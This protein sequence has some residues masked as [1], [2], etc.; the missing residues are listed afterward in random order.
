MM[1]LLTLLI[2]LILF[3][4]FNN[5]HFE[6]LGTD[7]DIFQIKNETINKDVP[8]YL[9]GDDVIVGYETILTTNDNKNVQSCDFGDAIDKSCDHLVFTCKTD[10]CIDEK[11]VPLLNINGDYRCRKIPYK[12]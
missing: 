9:N 6:L 3:I 7:D 10:N 5:E 1:I 12:F 2:I 11:V 8:C 4:S